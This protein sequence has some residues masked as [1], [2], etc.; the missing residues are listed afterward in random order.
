MK[1]KYKV[2][3]YSGDTDG[4]VPTLGTRRWIQSLNWNITNE[5]RPWMV[6][7]Q[8]AGYVEKYDGLDFVTVHGTGHMAPQWKPQE[9]TTMVTAWIWGEKF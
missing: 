6:N 8:V 7:G 1:N 3:I 9:V 2:L 5:W 4:A